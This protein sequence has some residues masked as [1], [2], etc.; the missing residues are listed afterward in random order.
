E[1]MERVSDTATNG[2]RRRSR[3]YSNFD[4]FAS[5]TGHSGFILLEI[6]CKVEYFRMAGLVD[7]NSNRGN[8]YNIK[9]CRFFM[10]KI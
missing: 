9:K 6:E 8:I 10:D 2:Y 4:D 5:A 1:S 3:Q 7:C